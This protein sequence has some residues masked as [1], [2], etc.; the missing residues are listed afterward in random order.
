M[1]L[2]FIHVGRT[3]GTAIKRALRT[4]GWACWAS[5]YEKKAPHMPETRYG[6]IILHRHS[7]RLFE[8]ELDDYVFFSL[9]DPI[10][11]FV[12]GFYSRRRKGHPDRYIEWRKGER[13]AFERFSTPEELALALA[14]WNPV[15]R[16]AAE[17]AMSDVMHLGHFSDFLGSEADLRAK[18]SHVVYILRQETLA[19]DWRQLKALL[20]LTGELKLHSSPLES[21]RANDPTAPL[22]ER[23]RAILRD[24][25]AEDYRLLD[26]CDSVR[27]DHGWGAAG[28]E[29]RIHVSPRAAAERR[30]PSAGSLPS[31][32]VGLM[33][34]RTS[35]R[36]AFWTRFLRRI[37]TRMMAE[38]GVGRGNFAKQILDA[39]PALEAYYMI[40]PSRH[41]DDWNAPANRDD[42]A[43][44]PIF[45]E[46]MAATQKHEA[47]RI[48]LRGRTSEVL[49]EIPA[50]SLDFAYINGDNTLRGIAIDLVRIFP[51]VREGGWIGGDHF[52][53]SAWRHGRR[54]EPTL[55]LPFA[56]Y[57]AEAV[58]TRIYRLPHKQF[59]LRK[60]SGRPFEFVALTGKHG[61]TDVLNHVTP[62]RDPLRTWMAVRQRALFRLRRRTKAAR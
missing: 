45:A 16:W 25:Y 18:L 14:S 52:A 4:A 37:D 15:K 46:A 22:N 55:V 40:D 26:L 8:L 38:I 35:D 13:A 11:R 61:S 19:E 59:L 57:F 58:G 43:F 32:E 17:R 30:T 31:G 20:G 9:R 54:F 53:R 49:D 42:E 51:K 39:C 21:H 34:R 2:H 6:H 33:A 47:K 60:Q 1:T 48:V 36:I 41:L 24:W 56:A 10:S 50:G 3:G 29:P 44:S 28:A 12:S 62:R 23:A 27:A 5:E 7:F